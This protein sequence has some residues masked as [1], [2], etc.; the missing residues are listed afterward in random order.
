MDGFKKTTR[1]YLALT[2]LLTLS[3][4]IGTFT[5]KMEDYGLISAVFHIL[6]STAYIWGWQ[7]LERRSH[8][9]LPKYYLAGS[10]FRLMASAA[11]LLM[12]CVVK[13]DNP[14]TIKWFSI[15]FIIFYLVMLVFDAIFFAIVSKNKKV[16]K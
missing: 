6:C 5:V 12:F 15:V 11:V 4:Y 14:E 7:A 9:T 8:E 16:T 1:E 13:R 10:A 3:M 2:L